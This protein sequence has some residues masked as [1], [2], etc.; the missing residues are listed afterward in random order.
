MKK[1]QKHYP[2]PEVLKDQGIPATNQLIADVANDP[3]AEPDID[4]K[5]YNGEGVKSQL[6]SDQ[7]CKCAYCERYCNGDYGAIEHYRPQKGYNAAV[8]QPLTKPG[9]YWLAYDWDNM[10]YSCS[11][12]NSSVKK[13]YFPLLDETTRNISGRD[14]SQERPT[15]LNPYFDNPSD[16]IEFHHELAVAKNTNPATTK[17]GQDTIDYLQLNKRVGLM[18]SRRQCWDDYQLTARS[19]KALE[20]IFSK[21]PSPEVLNLLYELKNKLIK[22]RSDQSQFSGMFAAQKWDL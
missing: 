7:H 13:N 4:S 3:M 9:Y 6:L 18:S 1:L 14:I 16:Y 12:C 19:V 20:L 21:T 5:I 15:I 2:A 17:I 22:M 11:E 10:L 8:G